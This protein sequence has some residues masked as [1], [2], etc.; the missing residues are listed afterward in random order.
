MNLF[1]AQCRVAICFFRVV[2]SPSSLKLFVQRQIQSRYSEKIYVKESFS[3][4]FA[5]LDCL[6]VE[7]DSGS[8]PACFRVEKEQRQRVRSLRSQARCVL[9]DLVVELLGDCLDA[10]AGMFGNRRAAAQRT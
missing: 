3:D 7:R 2:Q 9:V 8:K 10:F 6:F 1:T 5:G 4:S